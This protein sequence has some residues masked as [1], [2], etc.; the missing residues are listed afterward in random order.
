MVAILKPF[1]GVDNGL[2]RQLF[3]RLEVEGEVDSFGE[4]SYYSWI[5]DFIFDQNAVSKKMRAQGKG[6]GKQAKPRK[7]APKYIFNLESHSKQEYLDYFNPEHE[8]ESR[9]LGLPQAVSPLYICRPLP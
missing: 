2:A 6:K 5:S 8:V 3:K 4:H 7:A 1:L 9:L